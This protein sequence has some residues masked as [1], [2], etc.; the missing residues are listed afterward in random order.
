MN[1]KLSILRKLKGFYQTRLQK[2]QKSIE[3]EI[4][5]KAPM[6]TVIGFVSPIS[7]LYKVTHDVVPCEKC[8]KPIKIFLLDGEVITNSK[9]P[10]LTNLC[11]D[12]LPKNVKDEIQKAK[13]RDDAY[14][15]AFRKYD[16]FRMQLSLAQ[17][18]KNEINEDKEM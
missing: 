1:L 10:E 18:S 12:C 17:K 11:E 7:I 2:V 5:K 16:N 3:N 4:L 15:E 6:G 14:L 13:L 9:Y 8:S